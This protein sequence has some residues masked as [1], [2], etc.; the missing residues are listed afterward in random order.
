MDFAAIAKQLEYEIATLDLGRSGKPGD[1]RKRL[2][3]ALRAAYDAGYEARQ[4]SLADAM[5]PRAYRSS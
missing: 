3:K 2:E 4:H 5:Y 1:A